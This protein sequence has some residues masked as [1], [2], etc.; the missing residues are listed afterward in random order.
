MNET[1]VTAVGDISKYAGAL[2]ALT[3][4]VQ[5]LSVARVVT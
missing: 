1:A 5:W 3:V 2:D 4:C